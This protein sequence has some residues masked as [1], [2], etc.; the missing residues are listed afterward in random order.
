MSASFSTASVRGFSTILAMNMF[1]SASAVSF[2][3]QLDV[4]VETLGNVPEIA[5]VRYL[6]INRLLRIR[7]LFYVAFYPFHRL[8]TP[9]GRILPPFI[10][11]LQMLNFYIA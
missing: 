7:N 6:V 4:P 10:K 11:C 8:F 9:F 3:L 5:Q 2:I 1:R